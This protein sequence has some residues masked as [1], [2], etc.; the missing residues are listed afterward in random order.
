MK[1]SLIFLTICPK[2]W[3]IYLDKEK[4]YSH[5]KDLLSCLKGEEITEMKEKEQNIIFFME[6]SSI[7]L[8]CPQLSSG[9]VGSPAV[10]QPHSVD[11]LTVLK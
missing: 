11:V 8:Q 2:M 7:C 9:T 1:D 6:L 4:C 10:D 3:I 5:E